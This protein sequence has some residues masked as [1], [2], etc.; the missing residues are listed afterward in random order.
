MSAAVFE[1]LSLLAE[2]L[3]ARA[4]RVLAR[5]PL[6]VGEL[7][8]VLQTSQPT[9]S[10]HLKALAGPGWVEGRKVGTATVYATTPALEAAG[11]WAPVAAALDADAADPRSACAEDLRRLD[12][13]VAQRPGD[14]EALFRQLGGR[15]DEL[16]RE[17]FGEAFLVPTLLTLAPRLRLAVDL[18]CGTGFFL[19]LLAQLAD[20]VI[21]VDREEAVLT[22]ARAKVADHP[23]V[24]VEVGLLDR[25][26]LPTGAA[27]LALL[28]LVLHHVREIDPVLAE[29]ARCLRPGGRLVVLDM[30]AH[31]RDEWRRTLGH[32]HPG[33]DPD[34]LRARGAAVGLRPA[35]LQLLPPDREAQGPGLFVAEWERADAKAFQR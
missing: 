20:E 15:W 32:A 28:A 12:V 30:C 27:D 10:R 2:P 5:E 26:P 35:R 11:L 21:G 6:A 29:A 16:R 22:V 8:R 25:L 4:L 33:F 17:Q 34:A 13:V 31:D 3:R 14:S 7:A 1:G 24:R 23:G 18:G 19:P 9:V